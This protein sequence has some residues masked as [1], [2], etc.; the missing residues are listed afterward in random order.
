MLKTI[1]SFSILLWE[2]PSG[3]LADVLGRKISLVAG[4][5]IWSFSWLIYCSQTSFTWFVMA[6]IGAGLAGSL[7]SGADTA[8]AY[9]SLLQLKQK[10]KYP[11]LEGRLVAIAGVSEACCGI[12]GGALAGV[13]LVY[14]FY[15]Q[16]I[17]IVIYSI[18]AATL[19]EPTRT[20][21]SRNI[22]QL[23]QLKE[24]TLLA[25]VKNKKI[26]WLIIFSGISGCATFLIVWLSQEYLKLLQIPLANFGSSWAL[27]HLVMSLASI[28]A[29]RLEN[30]LGS[31]KT[32]YS[33]VWLITVSYFMLALVKQK[34]GLIFIATIYIARGIK[35]PIIL[36]YLNY[37]LNSDIRATVISISS[38]VFRLSFVLIAP[39]IGWIADFYY[40]DIALISFSL[41]FLGVSIYAVQNLIKLRVI[42]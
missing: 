12:I 27:F 5:I 14:P 4:G 34:W 35:S 25:L 1:L 38:F 29:A 21:P 36:N 8:I 10:E 9:D 3:Y 26:K 11:Q 24:I 6:E 28:L 42:S 33:L 32:F 20:L 7:I 22:N 17:C 13:N 18:L 19:I 30:N 16:T 23:K 39:I 2:I 15:L 37:Y 41:I 31:K 40:F